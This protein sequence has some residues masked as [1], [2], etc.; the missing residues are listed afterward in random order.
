MNKDIAGITRPAIEALVPIRGVRV[1]EIGCGDG[2]ITRQ[3]APG[4]ELLAGVEPCADQAAIA[5]RIKGACIAAAAAEHLPFADNAFDTVLFTLSLHHAESAAALR[6]AARVTR[7]GGAIVAVE[8][9]PHG[10]V[11]LLSHIFEDEGWRLER[12][13]HALDDGDALAAAG[14]RITREEIF[15]AHWEFADFEE[16]CDYQFEHFD[17]PRSDTLIQAALD[18]LGPNRAGQ[19]PIILEDLLVAVVLEV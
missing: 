14:T 5:G 3:L 9:H 18:F 2:R 6:E 13:R 1:L 15:A 11:Q 16:L 10:T 19:R 12:A 8:P 7:P 4:P 17:M